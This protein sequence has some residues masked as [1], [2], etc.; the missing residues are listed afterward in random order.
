[1]SQP[2]ELRLA[3]QHQAAVGGDQ[4]SVDWR[5]HLIAADGW[6]IDGKKDIVGHGGWGQANGSA[7]FEET[8]VNLEMQDLIASLK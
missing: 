3:Q 8:H 4:T 6:K 5:R 7:F 1:M 2:S